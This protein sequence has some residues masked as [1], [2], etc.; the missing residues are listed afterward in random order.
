MCRERYR[1][2]IFCDAYLVSDEAV[3]EDVEYMISDMVKVWF[4]N[5]ELIIENG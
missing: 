5:G 1:D 4:I 3:Y 2:E